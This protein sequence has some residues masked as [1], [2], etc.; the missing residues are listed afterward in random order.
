MVSKDMQF[1]HVLGS[2]T[3]ICG[4]NN[5]HYMFRNYLK[6]ALRQLRRQGFYSGIK[7]GGVALGIATCLLISLYIRNELSYDTRY[8]HADRIYR[9]IVDYKQDDGVIGKGPAVP[10]PFAQVFKADYPMV[11]ESGRPIP[12]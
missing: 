6:V 7:I 2:P 8:A 12:Y 11:E 9:V 1:R 4:I 10:P 5:Q 3:C